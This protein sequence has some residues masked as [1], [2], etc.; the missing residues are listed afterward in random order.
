[1]GQ[2]IGSIARSNAGAYNGDCSL[3]I[4]A[5]EVQALFNNHVIGHKMVYPIGQSGLWHYEIHA[6]LPGI[7]KQERETRPEFS[8]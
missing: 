6:Y 7:I 3:L 1:M 2:A 8:L 4:W 5:N